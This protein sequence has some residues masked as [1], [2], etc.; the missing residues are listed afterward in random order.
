[1]SAKESISRLEAERTRLQTSEAQLR[2]IIN[3]SVER[4]NEDV[5]AFSFSHD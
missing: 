4:R 5:T 3:Q 2:D 1:M